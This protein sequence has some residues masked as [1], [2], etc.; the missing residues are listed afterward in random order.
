MPHLY[1]PWEHR[2]QRNRTQDA[3]HEVD[4][5][6]SARHPYMGIA[7]QGIGRRLRMHARDHLH[8]GANEPRGIFGLPMAIS[9]VLLVFAML[10]GLAYI[11]GIFY[12]GPIGSLRFV[13]VILLGAAAG[14]LLMVA[15]LLVMTTIVLVLTAPKRIV[16]AVRRL[17]RRGST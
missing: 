13:G 4:D 7:P 10:L 14:L 11:I 15:I 1:K 17:A 5:L 6:L 3:R 16:G 12:Y 2:R 9:L 8:D